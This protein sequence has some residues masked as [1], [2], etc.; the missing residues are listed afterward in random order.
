M[1]G[2]QGLFGPHAM[3]TIEEI[4]GWM[5]YVLEGVHYMC[6]FHWLRKSSIKYLVFRVY[7]WYV[8]VRMCGDVR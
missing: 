4:P 8:R 6:W 5:G 7:S 2:Y 3:F 1:F